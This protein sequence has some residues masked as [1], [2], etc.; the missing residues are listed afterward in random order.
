MYDH[1]GIVVEISVSCFQHGEIRDSTLTA[2]GFVA[3]RK[4]GR[5]LGGHSEIFSDDETVRV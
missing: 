5:T 2:G 4:F 1:G 3:G